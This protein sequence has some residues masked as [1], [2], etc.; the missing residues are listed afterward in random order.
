MAQKQSVDYKKKSKMNRKSRS[1]ENFEKGGRIAKKAKKLYP[2]KANQVNK[3][4]KL[5]NY[6]K[7]C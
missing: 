3:T 6:A 1:W 2:K 5:V 7:F 4:L